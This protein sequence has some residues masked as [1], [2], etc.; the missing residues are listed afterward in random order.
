MI[1]V[2]V[3]PVRIAASVLSLWVGLWTGAAWGS[4]FAYVTSFGDRTVSVI[5]TATS[6]AVALVRVVPPGPFGVAGTPDGT[7]VYVT[8]LTLGVVSVKIG[9]AH[10]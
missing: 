8:H 9:R 4:P 10:V 3:S 5:D 7:R 2:E 1:P 6:T